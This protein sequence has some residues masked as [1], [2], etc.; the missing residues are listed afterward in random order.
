MWD[1]WGVCGDQ[2]KPPAEDLC[3]SP[4]QYGTGGVRSQLNR[5]RAGLHP[6]TRCRLPQTT[7]ADGSAVRAVHGY[8]RKAGG[9]EVVDDKFV[10]YSFDDV[11]T[12]KTDTPGGKSSS[13]KDEAATRPSSVQRNESGSGGEK[14]K[15]QVEQKWG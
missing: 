14:R 7:W 9:V 3:R 10:P 6:V 5:L 13:E 2:S 11:R 15:T 12:A 8:A 1:V 4:E